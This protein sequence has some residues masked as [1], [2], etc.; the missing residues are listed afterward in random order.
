MRLLTFSSFF[1]CLTRLLAL[2]IALGSTSA[3]SADEAPVLRITGDLISSQTTI[4]QQPP[5][6][7][8]ADYYSLL[9]EDLQSQATGL[10]EQL[11]QLLPDYQVAFA[12][13]DT[14]EL[15]GVMAKAG[16]VWASIR[17]L[18]AQQFTQEAAI[19]L[20]RAYGDLF[21]FIASSQ[22]R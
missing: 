14:A 3:M 20:S 1:S 5:R 8:I 9:P 19:S 21:P 4:N 2:C 10:Q 6:S 12:S 18:H 22:N 16:F 17:T 7:L 15:N 13:A 11:A